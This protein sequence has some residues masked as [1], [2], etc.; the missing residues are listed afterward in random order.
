MRQRV[1]EKALRG[2]AN[3]ARWLQQGADRNCRP[4]ADPLYVGAGR[5]KFNQLEM[6]SIFTYKLSQFGEDQCTQFRVIVVTDPQTHIQTHRQDRL[7]YTASQLRYAQCNKTQNHKNS[8]YDVQCW[9]L[10]SSLLY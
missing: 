7:Q 3:T 6:V 5:P 1:N 8:S 2:D 4:A 10:I 9:I